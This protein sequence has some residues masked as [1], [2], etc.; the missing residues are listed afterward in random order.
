MVERAVFAELLTARRVLDGLD[1]VRLGGRPVLNK[2]TFGVS[3]LLLSCLAAAGKDKKKVLLPADVLHARTVLVVVDPDAGVDVQDPNANRTARE[4][5]EKAIEK[6][7]RFDLVTDASTADLI[8]SI[9]KSN[10]KVAQST[11][12]GPPVNGTPPVSIGSTTTPDSSTTH[13]A[14]RWGNSGVPGD[15]SNTES[16]SSPHPQVEAGST[17]DSFA[18]YRGTGSDPLDA[19]SVWRYTAKNALASPD[20]P[21]VEAFR[22]LVAESEK[23]LAS[24]P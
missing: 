21:A 5:V 22:K 1:L 4:D 9:R 17:Q 2:R 8:I 19:P 7:G 10:G 18:V 15:P 13:A 16:P 11:I 14:G 12:G 6:W 24:N 23:Q 20:V 3:I